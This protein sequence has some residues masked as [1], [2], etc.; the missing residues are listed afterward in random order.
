MSVRD[1]EELKK[2][3]HSS[4]HVEKFPHGAQARCSSSHENIASSV[5][6]FLSLSPR[7][8]FFLPLGSRVLIG[9]RNFEGIVFWER[10]Y[11]RVCTPRGAVIGTGF[12]IGS[13]CGSRKLR[14]SNEPLVVGKLCERWMIV[15]VTFLYKSI[16][17]EFIFIYS[18]L[19]V[20]YFFKSLPQG[21]KNYRRLSISSFEFDQDFSR[22]WEIVLS[23]RDDSCLVSEK[24]SRDSI[25]S[26]RCLNPN[27]FRID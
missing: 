23:Y 18:C 6:R 22:N 16:D 11:M 4:K 24:N 10:A 8:I 1:A 20:A 5:K 15:D 7:E 27:S 21:F 25:L 12:R 26:D 17:V 19:P 3:Q 2:F 9:Q 14:K 13:R